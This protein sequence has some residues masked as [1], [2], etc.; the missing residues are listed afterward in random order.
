MVQAYDWIWDVS[1]IKF[2]PVR[3]VFDPVYGKQMH[4]YSSPFWMFE[5]TLPP[6]ADATRAAVESVLQRSEGISVFNVYDPR[7]PIP[8]YHSSE[9]VV[10]ALNVKG[11]TRATSSITVNGTNGDVITEGDPIA[12][13]D[14]DGRRHYYKASEDLTLT[15]LD[16]TLDVF[17]RPRIDL[18]S[19]D[20]VADRI[21]PTHRFSVNV[22]DTGGLT[23]ARDDRTELMLKGVEYWGVV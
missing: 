19:V 3:G 20:I 5:L 22:N 18:A 15:G 21:R 12:F 4:Q 11:V 10:P 9:G 14:A 17:I 13:T 6:A 2:M 7:R 8:A 1:S 16:Q 23:T